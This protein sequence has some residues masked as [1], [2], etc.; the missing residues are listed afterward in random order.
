MLHLLKTAQRLKILDPAF[1]SITY[2]AGGSTRKRTHEV[3]LKIQNEI[4]LETM[5]HLTCVGS[6]RSEIYQIAKSYRESGV[7]NILALRG[8][9]P[10]DSPNFQAPDDGFANARE[11]VG[12][13]RESFGS[14]FHLGVAGYPEK[15]VEALTL[16]QDLDYLKS[17]VDQ[18]ANFIITQL[19]LENEVFFRFLEKVRK[20]G[21]QVPVLAGIMPVSDVAQIKKF[22]GMIGASLPAELLTQLER[23]SQQPDS[24]EEV[25]KIGVGWATRQCQR[26]L[27][28]KVDGIHFYTLNKSLPTLEIFENLSS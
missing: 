7:E 18:G 19:F 14:F 4:G 1:V 24:Q 25:R 26:L 13:L 27:E 11:L 10:K 5:A 6:S 3:T 12:F 8:D 23:A 20:R 15:H 2:G 17:K 28:Q 9:P 22:T 21:I 16:D